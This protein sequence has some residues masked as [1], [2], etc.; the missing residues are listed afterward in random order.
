MASTI[1]IGAVWPMAGLSSTGGNAQQSGIAAQQSQGAVA[2]DQVAQMAPFVVG[3]WAVG[4]RSKTRLIL[5]PTLEPAERKIALL[6][7]LTKDETRGL[8]SKHAVAFGG[9][10]IDMADG[11]KT[12][13]RNPG[14][15]GGVAPEFDWS[16]SSNI[17][18]VYV[19]FPAPSRFSNSYGYAVGYERRV[20]L[21]LVIEPVDPTLPASLQLSIFYGVCKDICVPV[22]A[23]LK[24]AVPRVVQAGSDDVVAQR[25][26]SSRTVDQRL[27]H[28]RLRASIEALPE[29]LDIGSGD[30]D[31]AA[32]GK[33]RLPQ[34]VGVR[35]D[36]TDERKFAQI[37][38]QFDVALGSSGMLFAEDT[39]DF[40]VGA[41]SE[42]GRPSQGV[43]TFKV[44]VFPKRA[45][46]EASGRIDGHLAVTLVQG[47]RA[48]ATEVPITWSV[49]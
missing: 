35:I 49:D 21:P 12:Y 7:V 39:D 42:N 47:Q 33:M 26:V 19:G 24:V 41:V 43:Q 8:A 5:S 31:G 4:D 27:A 36:V 14:T 44:D 17:R 9:V 15:D 20:M 34:V 16:G 25:T 3:D 13:W 46:P 10:E 23:R 37:A 30:V 40:R 29:R 48:V 2:A 18:N 32:S 1:L 11:F 45:A 38:V 22:Q 6:R 28:A